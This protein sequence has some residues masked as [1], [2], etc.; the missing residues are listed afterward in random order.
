MMSPA[1]KQS[2]LAHPSP[3][4]ISQQ[5]DAW[6]SMT[7]PKYLASGLRVLSLYKLFCTRRALQ[8]S[9]INQFFENDPSVARLMTETTLIKHIHTIRQMGGKIPFTSSRMN[10][11]YQLLEYPFTPPIT[12][13]M[14][15]T[16]TRTFKRLAHPG[17]SI[18][19]Y[20]RFYLFLLKLLW[21]LP[22]TLRWGVI[23]GIHSLPSQSMG[24]PQDP[25]NVKS[26]YINDFAKSQL[27]DVFRHAIDYQTPL[28]F[29][30]EGF[31]GRA[32][33]KKE[34]S[35]LT[36]ETAP[37]MTHDL[38]IS[39]RDYVTVMLPTDVRHEK[40]Q[41]SLVG[42]DF[43][44]QQVREIPLTSAMEL[45]VLPEFHMVL[46]EEGEFSTE[47]TT[48]QIMFRL[49][50]R[51]A[52]SYEPYHGEKVIQ[53]SSRAEREPHLAG[54]KEGQEMELTVTAQTQDMPSVLRRL[55]KYGT[56][57][58]VISPQLAVKGMRR[59]LETLYFPLVSL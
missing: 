42:Y 48:M 54:T 35:E 57:C 41:Y 31:E 37:E 1:K 19:L 28:A 24:D 18:Q 15:E 43:L 13:A 47:P 14:V 56:Q 49:T 58:Q 27:L 32:R 7:Q 6:E 34:A 3:E 26:F 51:L 10:H 11:Q 36:E 38:E 25:A 33:D 46:N 45:L 22:T 40:R 4:D 53:R 2:L 23:H 30:V 55:A 16:L 17:A 8:L 20:D 9:D 12:M 5:E 52:L 59:Y 44:L 50:G 39:W 29:S 21:F